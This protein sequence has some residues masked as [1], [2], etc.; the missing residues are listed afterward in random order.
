MA[1]RRAASK[2]L[3]VTF[4]KAGPTPFFPLLRQNRLVI[5]SGLVRTRRSVGQQEG[6][7][8]TK[9]STRA[10]GGSQALVQIRSPERGITGPRSLVDLS[11]RRPLLVV[12]RPPSPPIRTLK[13]SWLIERS[14]AIPFWVLPFGLV[15]SGGIEDPD[16]GA[17]VGAIEMS[18]SLAS[19]LAQMC[20]HRACR[21]RV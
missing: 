21:Q 20:D 12:E 7:A 17:P 6:T 18:P 8:N 19:Q 5:P 15:T 4:R 13:P 16:S 1:R 2:R 3:S 9:N 14:L 11:V 10:S